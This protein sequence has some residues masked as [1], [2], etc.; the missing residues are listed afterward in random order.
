MG[1]IKIMHHLI[2]Y[3]KTTWD[4]AQWPK[5]LPG[6]YNIVSWSP[7]LTKQN[8]NNKRIPELKKEKNRKISGDKWFEIITWVYHVRFEESAC[9]VILRYLI[10]VWKQGGLFHTSGRVH[11]GS[12]G[13]GGWVNRVV[14]KE[15][16]SDWLNHLQGWFRKVI[17]FNHSDLKYLSF[18]HPPSHSWKLFSR[19]SLP[20]LLPLHPPKRAA[21][22]KR[23]G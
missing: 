14:W 18:E 2:R 9:I 11:V 21:P 17:S 16:C 22:S 6:K 4:L 10:V 23:G 15:L 12:V 8:N 5:R 3:N 19:R 1:Q 20:F 13:A 7:I